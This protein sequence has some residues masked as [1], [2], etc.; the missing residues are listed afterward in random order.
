MLA[1]D[2]TIS[3]AHSADEITLGKANLVLKAAGLNA[4]LI[5]IEQLKFTAPVIFVK[6]Y[7]AFFEEKI[8]GINY[9]P[10]CR[11]EHCHNAELIAR[12]LE[13]RFKYQFLQRVTGAAIIQGDKFSIESI[14]DL[15]YGVT[16]KNITHKS[17]RYDH[18][19]DDDEM[20]RLSSSRDQNASSQTIKKYYQSQKRYPNVIPGELKIL[21]D[22]VSFLENKLH[23]TGDGME[24]VSNSKKKSKKKKRRNKSH[25]ENIMDDDDNIPYIENDDAS[26]TSAGHSPGGHN[27]D[28][29]PLTSRSRPSTSKRAIFDNIKRQRRPTSAPLG[30]RPTA[31]KTKSP[32]RKIKY[33]TSSALRDKEVADKLCPDAPTLDELNKLY[34]EEMALKAEEAKKKREREEEFDK[35]YTYDTLTGRKLLITEM[36]QLALKRERQ[37]KKKQE[38]EDQSRGVKASTPKESYDYNEAPPAPTRPEWPGHRTQT[39]VE[40]YVVKQAKIRV[41]EPVEKY[42]TLCT[43]NFA[44]YRFMENLDIVISVE[45]CCNCSFHAMSLRHKPDEYVAHANT[46][47]KDLAQTCHQFHPCA[48]VGV[49]RFNANITKKSRESDVNSRIGALE[50]QVAFKNNKGVVTPELIY[51]KL[52]SRRWP[53]KSVLNQKLK[54]FLSGQDLQIYEADEADCYDDHETNGNQTYPVGTGDW[55]DTPLSGASWQYGHPGT[56]NTKFPVQW[57]FDSRCRASFPKYSDGDFLYAQN[58]EN[59]MGY[60]ESHRRPGIVKRSFKSAQYV[61][62]VALKLKYVEDEVVVPEEDCVLADSNDIDTS[63]EM[64]NGIPKPLFTVLKFAAT[65]GKAEWRTYDERRDKVVSKVGARG[66]LT[67]EFHLCR[68]SFYKL[69]HTLAW[70]AIELYKEDNYQ[71]ADPFSGDVVDVQLAYAEHILDTL[72]IKFQKPVDT[73]NLQEL[74]RKANIDVPLNEEEDVP[75]NNPEDETSQ[76][77]P[78]AGKPSP[79]KDQPPVVKNED[80]PT[81]EAPERRRSHEEPQSEQEK[82]IHNAISETVIESEPLEPAP[83]QKNTNQSASS[84]F[85]E[86]LKQVCLKIAPPKP[87]SIEAGPKGDEI[88]TSKY[89]AGA[90]IIFESLDFDDNEELDIRE[91]QE[92]LVKFQ[93]TCE[94][95]ELNKLRAGLDTDGDARI[96][97]DEFLKFL[98]FDSS[99]HRELGDIWCTLRGTHEIDSLSTPENVLIALE[100]M[101]KDLFSMCTFDNMI[102]SIVSAASFVQILDKFHF[103]KELMAG[104]FAVLMKSFGVDAKSKKPLDDARIK[105]FPSSP[106]SVDYEDINVRY[107]DFCSWLQPVDVAKVVKRIARFISALINEDTAME[108]EHGTDFSSVEDL[109]K[110]IDSKN[111]GYIS[112]DSFQSTIDNLGLPVSQA[113]VRVV[114]RHFGTSDGESMTHANFAKMLSGPQGGEVEAVQGS[115][116]FRKKSVM[117]IQP[118]VSKKMPTEPSS[119]TLYEEDD[120]F[121]E[122]PKPEVQDVFPV[123]YEPMMVSFSVIEVKSSAIEKPQLKKFCIEI[124]FLLQTLAITVGREHKQSEGKRHIDVDWDPLEMSET[125]LNNNAAISVRLSVQ[126]NNEKIVLGTTFFSPRKLMEF[127]KDK[128][129][130]LPLSMTLEDGNEVNINIFGR[131]AECHKQKVS[132]FSKHAESGSYNVSFDDYRIGHDD[133]DDDHYY[134]DDH[135][136]DHGHNDDFLANFSSSQ[137]VVDVDVDPLEESKAGQEVTFDDSKKY[138]LTLRSIV[139]SELENVEISGKN[140]N[141]VTIKLGSDWNLSTSVKSDSGSS[142]KWTYDNDEHVVLLD[143]KV[144]HAEPVQIEVFDKNEYRNDVIVAEGKI[145]ITHAKYHHDSLVVLACDLMSVYNQLAGKAKLF[146]EFEEYYVCDDPVHD[147]RHILLDFMKSTSETNEWRDTMMWSDKTE[148]KNWLG[149]DCTHDTALGLRLG[150]NGL[151]GKFPSNFCTLKNLSDIEMFGNAL[152]GPL[153][154]N[155]GELTELKTLVLSDNRLSGELPVSL[156]RCTKLEEVDISGNDFSGQIPSSLAISTLTTLCLKDNKFSGSIPLSFT[157]MKRLRTFT[158]DLCPYEEDDFYK[159]FPYISAHFDVSGVAPSSADDKYWA[160]R[161]IDEGCLI[162]VKSYFNDNEGLSSWQ[163]SSDSR[164]TWSGVTFNNLGLVTSVILCRQGLSAPQLPPNIDIL[165]NVIYLDFSDNEI[166]GFFPP[167]LCK[168][169]KLQHLF[170]NNNSL[171]GPLCTEI[172]QLSSLKTLNLSGN[173]LTGFLPTEL[174]ALEVLNTLSIQSNKFEGGVPEEVLML[175]HLQ[176]LDFSNNALTGPIPDLSD[177]I[178]LERLVLAGNQFTGS[179]PDSL[180][181]VSHLEHLDISFNP[182]T[183]EL[184]ASMS[185]LKFLTELDIQMTEIKVDGLDFNMRKK[186]LL[187]RVASLQKISL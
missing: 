97:L 56:E 106:S 6:I 61:D 145:S 181:Q 186:L 124:K 80:P 67:P 35:M 22:R 59:D 184:P 39:S 90:V 150:A 162:D 70:E 32:G 29:G 64:T 48:R 19:E 38:R 71:M 110:T 107:D 131:L 1:F 152:R 57:V 102:G 94:D 87:G 96:S 4:S 185:N 42:P 26:V 75:V 171:E 126:Q 166:S 98:H 173:Q 161:K 168:L 68:Q 179:V 174:S 105:A 182:L 46:V 140:D 43:Q 169:S 125:A 88:A 25:S 55:D 101:E 34:K 76:Q 142:A 58:I 187:K 18:A 122:N 158:C 135:E 79:V 95:H 180:G 170:L 12:S 27:D 50:V 23:G 20:R 33:K 63:F 84:N 113:E 65:H 86:R 69:I 44:A 167:E 28:S 175:E 45:H 83:E 149:V 130:D 47:L 176:Q 78:V 118:I 8:P 129:F 120:F 53:S 156:S 60:I 117:G 151:N 132:K 146:F 36:E 40:D 73:I 114:F 137:V 24:N 51:S 154:Q 115:R 155:I 147:D 9:S 104:D 178:A 157:K 143:G 74:L 139:V 31:Q 163:Q 89:K 159:V 116:Q 165:Q 128:F 77:V 144:M 121:E 5:T 134:D 138:S 127:D 111:T 85:R 17:T 37:A 14:I 62:M 148:L 15:F 54:T 133:D 100:E 13:E 123:K 164:S 72:F 21:M 10:S 7:E 81:D 112:L 109:I 119:N 103:K 16:Q 66:R 3:D 49:V 177:L 108:E 52:K 99:H 82:I 141:Y 136:D 160:N 183:G 30:G 92:A 93:F 41:P 11:D 172:S 91:F 153:P 2:N